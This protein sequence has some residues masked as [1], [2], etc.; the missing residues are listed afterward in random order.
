MSNSEKFW[1]GI[2]IAIQVVVA[3]FDWQTAIFINTVLGIFS[4][5]DAFSDKTLPEVFYVNWIVGIGICLGWFIIG[6]SKVYKLTIGNFNDWLNSKDFSGI[7]KKK[8]V[9]KVEL[10]EEPNV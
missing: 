9:V 2:V 6:C 10:K 8:Q 7:F 5:I 4:I 1:S 3:F